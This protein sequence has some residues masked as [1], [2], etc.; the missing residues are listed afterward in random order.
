MTQLQDGDCP[1]SG[2]WTSWDDRDNP[3]STGDWELIH[4]R[5]DAKSICA[6]P[7]AV[8]ARVVE[9]GAMETSQTVRIDANQGFWCE[10]DQQSNNYCWDYEARFCC[11][12][13]PQEQPISVGNCDFG[14]WSGWLDL[15]N[16]SGTGDWELLRD[17]AE[18]CEFP[19]GVEGRIRHDT[20]PPTYSSSTTE[21]ISISLAGLICQNVNQQDDGMCEDYEIR[22]CCGNER[23]TKL[24]TGLCEQWSSWYNRDH[25]SGIGDWERLTDHG[26]PYNMPDACESP[27]AAEARPIGPEGPESTYTTEVVDFGIH[28]IACENHKQPDGAC[29]D[30]EV[31]W[32]CENN[33]I[34]TLRTTVSTTVKDEFTTGFETR[35]KTVGFE[36][37]P[38]PCPIECSVVCDEVEI[39]TRGQQKD[40]KNCQVVCE[41][42]DKC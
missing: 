23:G 21:D 10:N 11:D 42:P 35:T 16:P 28:G 14:S 20:S 37:T 34:T 2:E 8:Q 12:K 31:R 4:L 24:S 36:T 5:H 3:G 27:S 7:L 33:E 18:V 1:R 30:Y 15:D 9:T 29:M 40:P 13:E 25:P 41:S 38:K 39:G 17:H 26:G 19:S 22:Y 32:C 6:T